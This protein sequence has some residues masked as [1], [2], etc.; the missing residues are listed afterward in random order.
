MHYNDYTEKLLNLQE[1]TVKKIENIDKHKYIY[2][3]MH[4]K[5][6]CCPNCYCMTNTIHDYRSQEIKDVSA[7][8]DNVTLILKKRRYRCQSCGKRFI[9]KV[10]F[11]PRYYRMT[12]RL[13]ETVIDKLRNVTSFTDVAKD[14]NLSVSTVIRI[15][16][17]INYPTPKTLPRCVAIDEFK[18]NTGGE[19]YNCIITDPDNKV[20]L[21]IL[22]KR[23]K[24]YL[25]SYFKGFES[26]NRQQVQCFVSDMWTTYYD[27]ATTWLP[28]ATKVIDKYHWIRQVIW[29]FENIRKQEQKKFDKT[30][31]I[32]FKRSKSLLNKRFDYL[33]EEQKQQVNIMLYTSASLSTAY[34]LKED[35]L[36]L[37]DLKNQ[38][39]RI[40]HLNDWIKCCESSDLIPFQK[41]GETMYN[42]YSGILNS[43]ETPLTNGF[44]EGCN[45]KIKVIKR[46]AYGYR[47]YKR[48][49]NRILHAFSHQKQN[50]QAA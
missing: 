34:Y 22:P 8:G 35:F 37:L 47:N 11:L 14:V 19:K 42:W 33:T 15:F 10:E 2:I 13:I 17:K 27:I 41:A 28:N 23:Y 45:N 25:T 24:C 32:Y 7:F 26:C 29:A 49:R 9:E 20:V 39:E 21:D 30:H 4:R 31:R 12:N 6:H 40:K 3:Q 36:K 38:D 5:E 46:N 44:T 48:F 18:G 1:V 16:D 43:L 50:M